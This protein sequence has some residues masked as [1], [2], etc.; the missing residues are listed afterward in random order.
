ML[1]LD[2]GVLWIGQPVVSGVGGIS[3]ILPSCDLVD[4]G[5]C[6]RKAKKAHDGGSFK[7]GPK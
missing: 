7:T 6:V 2:R 1:E 5:L 3:I 4:E